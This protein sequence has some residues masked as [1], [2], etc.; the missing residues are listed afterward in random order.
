M[1]RIRTVDI[2]PTALDLADVAT[3]GARFD[4]ASLSPIVKGSSELTEDA[5]TV[6]E[7]HNADRPKFVNF[8]RAQLGGLSMKPLEHKL[9]GQ[10]VYHQGSRYV[11]YPGRYTASFSDFDYSQPSRYVERFD[12]SYY[13]HR[14][15][16]GDFDA[17]K[18]MLD[19]YINS[20]MT[21]GSTTAEVPDEIRM[22]LRAMGYSI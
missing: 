1:R 3:A 10:A 7:S 20:G 14:Q 5:T 16:G 18:C 13:P 19:E 4:G 8:Q 17:F 15:A 12:D 22:R 6:A 2:A 21:P 11:N 9:V